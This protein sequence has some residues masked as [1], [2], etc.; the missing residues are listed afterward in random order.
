MKIEMGESLVRTWVRHCR[1]CQFA[2]LNW[3]PSPTWDAVIRPEHEVWYSDAA[4]EFSSKMFKKTSS[5]SQFLG[6]AEIDVLGLR[7][8]QGR[9]G[10][11]IAADIAFHTNGLQYGSKVETA[12]RVTKKLFRTA[13]IL[14]LYF[15]D[16]P[17]EILFLSPKVNPA[18]VP[19]VLEAG[20]RLRD[21][22]E[23]RSRSF[24]FSA[25]INEVFKEK[26]MGEV[27]PLQ[28]NVADTSEL[29]LRAVQLVGLVDR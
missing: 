6:Q 15:P 28:R 26:V 21:F 23:G 1:G 11:I 24:Q 25:V 13:L 17:A 19:G 20:D 29:F 14:D 16:V 3:K 2:E 9:V 18:T 4:A 12:A 10:G 8:E 22:F 27:L 7:L 5:L